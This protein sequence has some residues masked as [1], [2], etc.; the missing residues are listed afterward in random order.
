MSAE[1][2]VQEALDEGAVP[3]AG[4]AGLPPFAVA[5]ARVESVELLSPSF[6]RVVFV[7]PDVDGLGNP[8]RTFDQRVKLVFPGR[9]GRLPDLSDEDSDWYQT[10]L[11]IPAEERGSM[12]TYSIRDLA[13]D[14]AGTTR[15]V[16]DFVLH[17]EPGATGPASRWASAAAPGDELLVIGPR[18]GRLDGG[19]IEYGPGDAG[20]ILLAGDETAAP[21]IARILEDIDPSSRGV[22]FIEVPHRGDRPAISAPPGFEVRW[23]DRAGADHGTALIPAV[24][25]HLGER[26][27]AAATLSISD[28]E[29]EDPLWETPQYSGLGE[30]IAPAPEGEAHSDCY[31]WIAGESGVVTT[32]RR[33]LVK[34]LGIARSRVAFMGYWRRGVAMRG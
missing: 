13:V 27:A 10:W 1:T 22:A 5:R 7:G 21:A 11:G 8:G 25:E 12:R 14:D 9:S 18:R 33:R 20:T 26:A 32:L 6:V 23:L 34:D 31:F 28:V 3:E 29:S 30:D 16:I 17:L 2:A 4:A 15:L 19:G 24:L